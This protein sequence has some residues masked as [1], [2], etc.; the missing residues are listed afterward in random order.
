MKRLQIVRKMRKNRLLFVGML[1][2][3]LLNI[4]DI[5]YHKTFR[6]DFL[7]LQLYW[8]EFRVT[9]LGYDTG[10]YYHMGQ[11]IPGA[12]ELPAIPIF[13][14]G[15]ILGNLI[16]PGFIPLAIAKWYTFTL[17]IGLC[18]LTGF[19]AIR[20]IQIPKTMLFAMLLIYSMP[21][22]W[23][24]MITFFNIGGVICFLLILMV[25][26]VDEHPYAAALLLA[27]SMMKPQ[28]AMPFVLILLLEKKWRTVI[29]AAGLDV[30]A[31]LFSSILTGVNPIQQ[32]LY[33]SGR[34]TAWEPYYFWFGL[35][36][37][38]RKLGLSSNVAMVSSMV[39]G[40][41][42]LVLIYSAEKQNSIWKSN[43]IAIY[44]GAAVISTVW[45]YKSKSD[46]V[47][48]ILASMLVLQYYLSETKELREKSVALTARCLVM[49]AFLNVLLFTEPFRILFGYSFTIGMTLDGWCRLIAIIWLTLVCKRGLGVEATCENV[50]NENCLK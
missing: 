2:L 45:M 46:F 29:A 8:E 49:L 47:I 12:Q 33:I 5:V 43:V 22:Y 11:Q 26:V 6:I 36:D 41:V 10:F 9:L 32:V 1:L 13:P 24:D 39:L 15:R 34:S 48:V 50:E 17:L 40:V 42:F 25:F 27:I 35:L 3:V 28:N 4:G 44:S 18:V 14:W 19:M 37:P 20:Y 16:C 23:R 38:L 21:F 30:G 31:W 7:D